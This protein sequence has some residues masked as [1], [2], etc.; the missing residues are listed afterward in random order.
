MHI[1]VSENDKTESLE[2]DS[3]GE[4]NYVQTSKDIAQPQSSPII[5]KAIINHPK[6]IIFCRPPLPAITDVISSPKTAQL[7]F[8]PKVSEFIVCL[9]LFNDVDFCSEGSNDM[10]RA[11]MMMVILNMYRPIYCT[12]AGAY[13]V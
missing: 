4:S 7:I 13:H 6:Q 12:Y 3:R 5:I 9:L 1:W 11:V 2:S 8:Q 10:A